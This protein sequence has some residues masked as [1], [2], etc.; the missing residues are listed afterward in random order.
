MYIAMQESLNIG[1][2]Q[3]ATTVKATDPKPVRGRSVERHANRQEPA[4]VNKVRGDASGV[5]KLARSVASVGNQARANQQAD[6]A[7]AS[8]Q[9]RVDQLRQLALAQ[10]DR[11]PSPAEQIKAAA[12]FST[13]EHDL[14]AIVESIPPIAGDLLPPLALGS[15]EELAVTIS[16]LK[17]AGERIAAERSAVETNQKEVRRNADALAAEAAQAADIDEVS[18]REIVAATTREIERGHEAALNSHA[19]SIVQ[20]AIRAFS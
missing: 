10:Q 18:A 20:E 19:S 8:A 7:L 4:F 2:G 14:A 15:A 12:G 9:R 13:V 3:S 1:A 17:A 16:A 5:R 11:A 6:K